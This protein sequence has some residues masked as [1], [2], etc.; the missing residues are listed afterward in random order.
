MEKATHIFSSPDTEKF[1]EWNEKTGS[2]RWCHGEGTGRWFGNYTA[3][4]LFENGWQGRRIRP[5]SL[6]NK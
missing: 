5:I 1:L 2:V 6:E 4:Q 3:E